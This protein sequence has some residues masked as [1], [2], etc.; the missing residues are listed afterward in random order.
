MQRVVASATKARFNFRQLP[1]TD[2]EEP[3]S[4]QI[5]R[6]TKRDSISETIPVGQPITTFTEDL[7][8]FIVYET[9]Y[10]RY[11]LILAGGAITWA[12]TGMKFLS[13]Q[14]VTVDQD[15]Q[16]PRQPMANLEAAE[17]S[18]WINLKAALET[19]PLLSWQRT[20]SGAIITSGEVPTSVWKKAVARRPEIGLLFEDGEVR[21]EVPANLRGRGAKGKAKGGN[22]N[23]AALRRAGSEDESASGN[24][25]E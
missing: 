22:M 9:S 12:P 11:P 17:V 3:A 8:Q 19:Q 2:A 24:D 21:K 16:E 18:I 7:P 10:Q 5:G 20:E 4:W 13:F 1:D 14:P 6:I 15:G 25:D 23:Q